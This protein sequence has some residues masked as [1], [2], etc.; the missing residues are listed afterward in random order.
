MGI[1]LRPD[2]GVRRGGGQ[3]QAVTSV[4]RPGLRIDPLDTPLV[5]PLS[6][7]FMGFDPAP[8]DLSRGLRFNLYNNKWGTNFPQW[9]EGDLTARFIVTLGDAE[10][11]EAACPG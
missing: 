9:W 3:L 10:D 5:A 6:A 8:P 2:R 4:R 1:W 7:P 11:L